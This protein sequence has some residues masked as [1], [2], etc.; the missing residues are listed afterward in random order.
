MLVCLQLQ[1]ARS[2]VRAT[3]YRSL[4]ACRK[5]DINSYDGPALC[6]TSRN[7]TSSPWLTFAA[8]PGGNTLTYHDPSNHL[9]LKDNCKPAIV[10]LVGKRTKTVILNQLLGESVSVPVHKDVFLWSSSQLR[11][12]GGNAPLLV[13][14]CG[15]QNSRQQQPP[16]FALGDTT[17]AALSWPMPDI[18]NINAALCGQVFLPFSSVLCCFVSDLG[19]PKA[20]AR[21]LADLATTPKSDLPSMPRILL[22]VE[23]TSDA[24]DETV[25]AERMAA[26][27]DEATHPNLLQT[28]HK[29][30]RHFGTF[31][32]LGLH[33]CKSNVIR[34]RALKRRLTAMCD[35]AMRERASMLTQFTYSHFLTLTKQLISHLSTNN[36]TVFQFV[37]GSRA[38]GFSTLLLEPCIT[39]FLQQ[40]PSQAWLWHF[41][42]PII[43]SALLLS[44]YQPQAHSESSASY[45]KAPAD[46]SRLCTRIP[47]Q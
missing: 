19:G 33:S 14:D 31:E 22:V 18:G 43:G 34:A 41:A 7:M 47:L 8:S 15:V 5:K 32:V 39:D 30:I 10:T 17:R 2:I 4:I 12:S 37:T 26:L 24:F 29:A 13:I 11:S 27:F 3:T 38:H 1:K 20:V 44:S 25:T 28:Q 42:A 16:N 36:S 6:S 21:W 35:A 46:Q 23:T 9:A 45:F 40:L